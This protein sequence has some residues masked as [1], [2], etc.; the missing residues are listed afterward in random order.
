[1]FI[2]ETYNYKENSCS[3]PVKSVM[4]SCDFEV[5]ITKKNSIVEI[6]RGSFSFDPSYLKGVGLEAITVEKKLFVIFTFKDGKYNEFFWDLPWNNPFVTFREGKLIGLQWW[7]PLFILE[8]NKFKLWRKKESL[9][10]KAGPEFEGVV[11]YSELRQ[12]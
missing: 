2:R 3:L 1:M 7:N 6:Y 9:Q 8:T 4:M 5:G 12:V 10:I 11:T